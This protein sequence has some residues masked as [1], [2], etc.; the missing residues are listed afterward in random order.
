MVTEQVAVNIHKAANQGLDRI[1]IQMRPAELGK[2]DIRMEVAQDGRMTA[3]VNVERQ[4]TYDMLRSDARNLAQTL[5]NAGLN[6]DAGSLSFNLSSRGQQ[7]FGDASPNAKGPTGANG[8]AD[9][10]VDGDLIAGAE[11]GLLGLGEIAEADENG[12]YDVWV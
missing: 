12:R 9:S 4:E 6:T 10:D 2:I 8:D 7:G 11:D 3:V 1:T 5:Q